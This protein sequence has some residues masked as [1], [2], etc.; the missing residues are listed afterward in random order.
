MPKNRMLVFN[1]SHHFLWNVLIISCQ[2]RTSNRKKFVLKKTEKHEDQYEFFFVMKFVVQNAETLRDI[3]ISC[4]ENNVDGEK[5][6]KIL[7]K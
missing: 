7:R 3:E 2:N 5:L 6:N 1:S 4:R